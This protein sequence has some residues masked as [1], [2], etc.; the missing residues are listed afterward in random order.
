MGLILVLD[1]I[2]VVSVIYMALRKGLEQALPLAAFLF[3]IFPEE[4]K[5]PIPGLFDLTTQRLV[6][7]ALLVLCM[8]SKVPKGSGPHKT[9]A[10]RR[11]HNIG[12][13]VDLVSR[14][15]GCVHGKY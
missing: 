11:N 9:T 13:V 15:F 3:V 6:V 1:I 14:D 5:I 7:V 10:C 4:A 12:V 2:T 8:I